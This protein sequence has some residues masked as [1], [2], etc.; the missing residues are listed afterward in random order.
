[1]TIRFAAAWGGR[2]PVIMRA[3]CPS[4]PLGAVND[5]RRESYGA[6]AARR[7]RAA[8]SNPHGPGSQGPAPL[9]MQAAN[10]QL[11]LAEALRHF[12]RHGL[13]AAAHARA[14]AKAARA[15]DDEEG[16]RWWISICRQLDR[17]MAE[18]L[19]RGIAGR[20]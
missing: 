4:A 12:A 5:N 14:N 17:R 1:M 20:R 7:A 13:S 16:Y 11:L 15:A 3:L 19:D 2:S 10:D 6:D 8:Y 9:P 18:A